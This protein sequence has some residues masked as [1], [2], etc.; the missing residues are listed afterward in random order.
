MISCKMI[1]LTAIKIYNILQYLAS[2]GSIGEN[3]VKS[4][5]NL[6]IFMLSKVLQNFKITKILDS[7][8]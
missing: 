4:K 5:K 6:N 1:L 2:F 7:I 8:G 3:R